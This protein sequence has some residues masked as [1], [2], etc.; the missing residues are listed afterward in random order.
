MKSA[1]TKRGSP[2][3]IGGMRL[4]LGFYLRELRHKL[5]FSLR[6][7]EDKC[8]V[9]DS[10]LLRIETGA[11]ECGLESFVRICAALGVPWGEVLDNVVQ[12]N[13]STYRDTV[14][15]SAVFQKLV[16]HEKN[17]VGLSFSVAQI[18]A[19]AAHLARCSRPRDR[20]RGATYPSPAIRAAF[21]SY[22]ERLD[23][24]FV[25]NGR[26]SLLT[27]ERMALLASLADD[28]V[29]ELERHGLFNPDLMKD[30]SKSLD[31]AGMEGKPEHMGGGVAG[32]AA[33]PALWM[34]FTILRTYF[35][36]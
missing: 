31:L 27:V 14:N 28:P 15:S 19:F 3:D 11:Q 33:H 18:A 7:L 13:F 36:Q 17:A 22:A 21:C 25:V 26:L 23:K 35:T 34:P 32:M 10:E 29:S 5:D 24:T 16:K 12:A 6:D 8:G 30:L 4:S 2:D 1:K 20:A 9:S